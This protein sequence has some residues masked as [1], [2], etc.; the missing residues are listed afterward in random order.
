MHIHKCFLP[1]C[2][3]AAPAKAVFYCSR[4]HQI[5]DWAV[6][7][8]ECKKFKD[9]RT[10][11]KKQFKKDT[12][13]SDDGTWKLRPDGSFKWKCFE[14][15]KWVPQVPMPQEFTCDECDTGAEFPWYI[16]RR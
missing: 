6:H 9:R 3:A 5:S 13:M 11:E 8:A 2:K 7:K 1:E 14:C 12:I 16:Y 15:N 4:E 10:E